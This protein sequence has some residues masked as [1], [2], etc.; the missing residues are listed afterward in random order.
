MDHWKRA[1]Q[2][3]RDAWAYLSGLGCDVA[4]LQECVPPRDLDRSK[5][6]T[7]AAWTVAAM[8]I[9]PANFRLTWQCPRIRGASASAGALSFLFT[10]C[11]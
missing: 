6:V 8:V 1:G 3:R 5:I 11:C 10:H 2:T 9:W 4:L 7:V